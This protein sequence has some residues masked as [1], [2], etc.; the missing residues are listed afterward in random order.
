[1]VIWGRG[2]QGVEEKSRD[3]GWGRRREILS[4]EQRAES[5]DSGLKGRG[6]HW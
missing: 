4:N 5:K 3:I 6:D 2:E 1:M